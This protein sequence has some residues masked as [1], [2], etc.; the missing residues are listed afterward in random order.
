MIPPRWRLPLISFTCTL[1]AA[2]ASPKPLDTAAFVAPEAV[3][4]AKGGEGSALNAL[5]DA[6]DAG[7]GSAEYAIGVGLAEGW[8]GKKDL[9]QA[10]VWWRRA[11]EHGNAD[12]KNALAVAYAEGLN[13]P[14]NLDAARRLWEE[15]AEH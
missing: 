8:A 11:A 2:C 13:G 1:L 10:L 4:R 3:A 12:A 15:A 14:A 9:E 5:R 7:S 6:A